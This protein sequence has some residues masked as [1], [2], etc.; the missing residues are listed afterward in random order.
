MNNR[1]RGSEALLSHLPDRNKHVRFIPNSQPKVVTT[2]V[3]E[4]THLCV[5]SVPESP[6]ISHRFT[7]R[8]AV[9]ELEAIPR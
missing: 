1:P 5:T 2:Y 8:P 9:F 6:K 3:A 7:R 4:V